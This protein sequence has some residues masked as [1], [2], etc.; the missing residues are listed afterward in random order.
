[1]PFSKAIA[2]AITTCQHF[3]KADGHHDNDESSESKVS[4]FY[5]ARIIRV[6]SLLQLYNIMP[7]ALLRESAMMNWEVGNM[8]LTIFSKLQ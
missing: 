3:L 1:M 7:S 2:M 8:L 4:I 6:D 5:F